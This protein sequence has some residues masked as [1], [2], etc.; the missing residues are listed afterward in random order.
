M[1][2]ENKLPPASPA[3][4]AGPESLKVEEQNELQQKSN[5]NVRHNSQSDCNMNSEPGKT[6]ELNNLTTALK[7]L[8]IVKKLKIQEQTKILIIKEKNLVLNQ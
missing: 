5:S 1:D 6:S 3:N 7:S 4:Q 8:D 2:E